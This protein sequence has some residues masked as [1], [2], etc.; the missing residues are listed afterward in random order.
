MGVGGGG[1][2]EP[3]TGSLWGAD[4]YGWDDSADGG[5]P[6]KP[7]RAAAGG[8]GALV[9]RSS[10]RCGGGPRPAVQQGAISSPPVSFPFSAM[11]P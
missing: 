1:G 10:S 9:S 6:T 2:L 11:L 4:R 3:W 5:D 8:G 7:L